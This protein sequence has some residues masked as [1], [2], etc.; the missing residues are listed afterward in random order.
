MLHLY[1][2]V[3]QSLGLSSHRIKA[4]Y[5][6]SSSFPQEQDFVEATAKE[7]NLELLTG[8]ESLKESLRQFLQTNPGMLRLIL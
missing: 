3:L 2:Q 7:F 4:L 8:K 6:Q 1:K 5:F